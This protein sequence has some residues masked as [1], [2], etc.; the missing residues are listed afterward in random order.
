MYNVK[1][2]QFEGPL[3]LL[4]ELIGKEK[5]DITNISL[6][7][8]A[9]QYLNYL[10]NK[11]EID[12]AN[13]AEFLTVASK[14]ILIKSKSLL[15]LLVLDNDEEEEIVD[16]AKQIAEYKKF[17]D[18]AID[19]GAM[20]E[21]KKRS[22][23]RESFYGKEPIFNPPKNIGV[24]ELRNIYENV[25]SEVPV[26]EKLDEERV[27]KIISLKE[28]IN[29]LRDILKKKA[30]TSFNKL[31][32]EETSRVDVIVSF[33]AMLEMVKQKVIIVEQQ[34]MFY[35]ITLKERQD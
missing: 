15:P 9:N 7:Q 10:E 14:L 26:M 8:V 34:E 5:L 29:V 11:K 24:K 4:L 27:K 2:E 18:I 13:L 22:F 19:L 3:D 16:L 6:A 30:E 35:D 17:K 12:L 33:L 31:V 32:G 25:L 1:L 20:I 23:S 21:N 28:R